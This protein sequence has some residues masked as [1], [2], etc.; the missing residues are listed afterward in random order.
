MPKRR[1]LALTMCPPAS[2]GLEPGEVGGTPGSIVEAFPPIRD[3]PGHYQ[4]MRRFTTSVFI[5]A[6]VGILVVTALLKLISAGGESPILAKAHPIFIVSYRQL[7]LALAF[8]ELI[9]AFLLVRLPAIEMKLWLIGMFALNA[10]FY[11]VFAAFIDLRE[12][13]CLGSALDAIGIPRGLGDVMARGALVF[14]L[15]GCL[16]FLL[17]VTLRCRREP[18]MTT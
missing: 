3:I 18:A 13:P 4:I 7:Y 8:A 10:V 6:V 12:C 5:R 1:L 16:A 14:M 2:P 15:L 11:H 17:P 9:L